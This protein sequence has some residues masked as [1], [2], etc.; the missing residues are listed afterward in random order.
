MKTR[1]TYD[2]CVVGGAG[3]V[4]VPLA[5]VTGRTIASKLF[6]VSAFSPSVLVE[7]IL[8]LGFCALIA[9]LVPARRAASIEPMEALRTE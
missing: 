7:A 3:H 5:L 9:G 8:V 6:G 1:E 4:G 2:V